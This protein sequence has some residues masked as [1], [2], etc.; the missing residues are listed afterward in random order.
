MCSCDV[1]ALW[2]AVVR[3]ACMVRPRA[4]VGAALTLDL[5]LRMARAGERCGIDAGTL[6]GAAVVTVVRATTRRYH[7]GSCRR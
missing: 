5:W 6:G 2:I 7:P 1:H 4:S 3:Y